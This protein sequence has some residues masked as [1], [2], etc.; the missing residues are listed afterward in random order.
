[1][2]CCG[3]FQNSSWT[4]RSAAGVDCS[5]FMSGLFLVL[6]SCWLL[7]RNSFHF[8]FHSLAPMARTINSNWFGVSD[9]Q[10]A[11]NLYRVLT[12]GIALTTVYALTCYTVMVLI[13]VHH[14]R[15]TEHSA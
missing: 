13:C 15:T 4:T 10:V 11:E 2:Y 5:T 3:L 14:Q 6:T 9:S 1:M 7:S 12:G 8:L